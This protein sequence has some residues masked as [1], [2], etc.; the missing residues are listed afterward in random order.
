MNEFGAI[1]T[2]RFD[3][4]SM[5]YVYIGELDL[6]YWFPKPQLLDLNGERFFA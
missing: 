3:G 6:N 2:P 5:K 4:N 1:F